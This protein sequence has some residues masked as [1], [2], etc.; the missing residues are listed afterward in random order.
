MSNRLLAVGTTLIDVK[1]RGVPG[2]VGATA[3]DTGAG[4][5]LVDPGPE[6]TLKFLNSGLELLAADLQDVTAI[7][8]T[9]IHLDHAGSVG[10]ILTVNPEITVYVHRNGA[11]HLVDPSRLL[12]SAARLY[13]EQMG[14]L[15][16]KVRPVPEARV[17]ALEGGE[18][19]SFG[20]RTIRVEYTP[21]HAKHHVSYLDE[22]TGLCFVGD[23]AGV[24]LSGGRIVL[25]V[26][27]PAD[28]DLMKWRETTNAI[29]KLRPARLVH[30][31][32]GPSDDPVAHLARHLGMLEDWADRVK[33][34][35]ADANS[36]QAR[37]Q[38]FA[39]RVAAE[40]GDDDRGLPALELALSGLTDS[41]LGLAQYWRRASG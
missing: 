19:L 12:A 25:P 3:L 23:T 13:G 36:D 16:G 38:E 30:T 9:H 1:F 2:Y 41:W 34:S 26:T 20:G 39:E 40:F 14:E 4:L 29:R 35:L 27:P 10:G 15:W 8:V 28:I 6:S 11:H 37:S 7:L 24:V 31:H 33:S 18:R 5:V 17:V 21:G 32:F 22:T